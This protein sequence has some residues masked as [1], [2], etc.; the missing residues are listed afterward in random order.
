MWV[1]SLGWEDPLEKEMATQSRFLSGEI[2]WGLE[3]S[4]SHMPLLLNDRIRVYSQDKLFS[5]PLSPEPI[6][7]CH[8]AV[9]TAYLRLTPSVLRKSVLWLTCAGRGKC[10]ADCPRR[11]WRGCW[12]GKLS[13]LIGFDHS[14]VAESMFPEA[15]RPVFIT[16]KGFRRITFSGIDTPQWSVMERF[17]QVKN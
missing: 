6:N 16:Y 3:E 5:F 11:E 14:H 10:D 8:I 7:P 15:H 9:S 13:K 17:D 12:A 1:Q 2:P 4:D